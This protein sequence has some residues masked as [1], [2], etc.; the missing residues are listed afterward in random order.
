MYGSVSSFVVPRNRNI[1]G[2]LSGIIDKAPT[3]SDIKT[4]VSTAKV[5]RFGQDI[6]VKLCPFLVG[7]KVLGHFSSFTGRFAKDRQND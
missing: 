4:Q 3:T 2:G 7:V 1:A 6:M 5:H